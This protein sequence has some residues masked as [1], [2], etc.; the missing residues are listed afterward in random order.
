MLEML[1]LGAAGAAGVFGHVKSKDFVQRRLRY[2]KIVEKP[3]VPVGLA[4]GAATA[5]AVA[6]L[7][8]ITAGPALLVGAGIGTGVA[9]GI[10]RARRG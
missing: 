1:A 8:I 6:A 10:R 4:T 9:A 5:L 3:A 7:P 2:T